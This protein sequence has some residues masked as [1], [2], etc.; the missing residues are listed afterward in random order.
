V[1]DNPTRPTRRELD[2][3]DRLDDLLNGFEWWRE[4]KGDDWSTADE[5]LARWVQHNLEGAA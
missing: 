5:M 1:S 4:V 2:L 3:Q